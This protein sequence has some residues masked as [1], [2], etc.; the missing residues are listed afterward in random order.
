M[1][2]KPSGRHLLLFFASLFLAFFAQYHLTFQKAYMWDGL[3]IYGV[4]VIFF[5][6]ATLRIE[7][8]PG[9]EQ[10]APVVPEQEPRG[11][12]RHRVWRLAAPA[13]GLL[14]SGVVAVVA[15]ARDPSQPFWDLLA[16]WVIS[17]ILAVSAVVDWGGL[18]RRIL[19]YS[20]GISRIRPEGALIVALVGLT[21]LLRVSNLS[22]IPYVLTG[23]EAAM[24]LEAVDILKG[25]LRNPFA[26]GW[27]S[28]PTL[29]FFIQAAFLRVLGISTAGLRLSSAL[30]SGGIAL[31][32]YLLARRFYGR[33][34]AGPATFFF[35]TYHFAIHYG[36]MGLNNIWDPF[37]ALG[38]LYGLTVG[39]EKR[40][41]AYLAMGGILTGLAIYFYM[42]A[43]LIPIILV[44]YVLYWSLRE[45][46]FW[47]RHLGHLVFF[48]VV[49]LVVALPLLAHFR[50]HPTNLTARWAL[51]GI[52]PSGWVDAEM[53]NT[54]RS[55]LS[56]LID[57]FLRA[58]L[59]F[60]YYTDPSFHYRPGIPLMDFFTSVFFVLGLTYAITRWRRREYFV[61][62][63]WLL[64]NV[65][66][67]GML[68]TNPPWSPRFVISIPPAVLCMTLG[69]VKVS[70]YVRIALR[71]ER[72][73]A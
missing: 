62:I 61:L 36:R 64:L 66:L 68:L 43:R 29:Y 31:L 72:S 39:M 5:A 41:P 16:L 53:A 42:G 59:G 15:D 71:E 63:V 14:L 54:G 47:R 24:G 44:V 37:F 9:D 20:P 11:S 49:A 33:R 69:M 40:R 56:V 26:T 8:A 25:V 51:L 60:N 34:I 70:E 50:A 46:G 38:S 57:Q 30:V 13:L 3:L 6:V 2:S 58:A 23:D 1:E 73:A 32:L 21:L 28:H 48:G 18:W 55:M 17:I 12:L 22:A 35:A 4:A 67:G 10:R 7:S 65:I 52:F 27:L 45:R 19:S